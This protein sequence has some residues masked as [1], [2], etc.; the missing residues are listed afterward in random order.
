L[1]RIFWGI[2]CAKSFLG[3]SAAAALAL[4]ASASHATTFTWSYTDEGSNFGSGTFEATADLATDPT[5]ATFQ[6][7]SVTG[8][9]QGQ[10]IVGLTGYG[11]ANNQIYWQPGFPVHFN[12]A[13]PYYH[14][15]YFGF[16]FTLANGDHYDLYEEA[17]TQPVGWSCGGAAVPYCLLGPNQDGSSI[18]F[19][20]P[21]VALTDFAVDA[22]VGATPLPATLPLFAS[23]L[24][25]LGLMAFRRKRKQA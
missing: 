23:G 14:V 5:G 17:G 25:A 12:P 2:E 24:S 4:S 21:V 11:T 20:D 16:G 7:Q 18:G 3:L 22:V 19:D 6:I 1:R 9:A 13:D 8:T 10:T 15:G